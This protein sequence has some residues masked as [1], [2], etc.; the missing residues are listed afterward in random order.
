MIITFLIKELSKFKDSISFV[1]VQVQSD[2]I[3]CSKLTMWTPEE[4]DC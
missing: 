3:V 1:H 2:T 4:D